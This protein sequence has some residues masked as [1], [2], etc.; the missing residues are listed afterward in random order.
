MCAIETQVDENKICDDCHIA[1][2]EIL[3]ADLTLKNGIKLEN[4]AIF[5]EEPKVGD[6]GIQNKKEM[7]IKF[8]QLPWYS[9]QDG[10]INFQSSMINGYCHVEN[11][12]DY[13]IKW[14]NKYN[15]T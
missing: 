14:I 10:W 12:I 9:R 3:V 15:L 13:K 11:I 5:R 8:Q 1:M 7:E 2:N 6:R 4:C